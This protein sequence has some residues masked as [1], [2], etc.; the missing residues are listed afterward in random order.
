MFTELELAIN[1][2]FGVMTFMDLREEGQDNC[3]TCW[4]MQAIWSFFLT[5]L[6]ESGGYDQGVT[7]DD[8]VPWLVTKSDWYGA[9]QEDVCDKILPYARSHG[10]EMFACAGTCWGGYMV[11]RLSGYSDFKAGISFHPAT[12][13]IAENVNKEKLYEVLDEVQCPQMVLTAGNDHINEKPGGLCQKIWSVMNF[14]GECIYREYSDMIHGWTVRGDIRNEA[15]N[16]C[17]KAS[18]TSML[19]FLSTHL[20]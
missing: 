14:G 13:F 11:T 1:V 5:F 19:G 10:A 9:R 6:E 12:T 3:V 16:N 7:S 17:A 2:S 20:K 8:L 18:F 15:I 4:L